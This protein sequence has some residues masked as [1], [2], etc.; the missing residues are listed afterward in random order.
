MEASEERF[1]IKN[2]DDMDKA[3]RYL[4]DE[5]SDQK[6]LDRKT[7]LMNRL[8][9]SDS[10]YWFGFECDYSIIVFFDN[11]GNQTYTYP[12]EY[13]TNKKAEQVVAHQPA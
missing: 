10:C 2:S 12:D 13:S 9:D 1:S 4:G 7:A 6:N 11:K 8:E 3:L 5:D